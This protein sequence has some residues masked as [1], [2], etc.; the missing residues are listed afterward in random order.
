MPHSVTQEASTLA[1][2]KA[3]DGRCQEQC[4]KRAPRCLVVAACGGMVGVLQKDAAGLAPWLPPGAEEPVSSALEAFSH[5]LRLGAEQQRYEQ[6]VLVGSANDLAWL[7]A[8][9]PMQAQTKL[10]AEIPYPLLP[11]WFGPDARAQLVAA[12]TPLVR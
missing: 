4:K 8:S 12:L 3:C 6:L 2:R 11:E 10:V 1:P 9:L 5:A 7:R